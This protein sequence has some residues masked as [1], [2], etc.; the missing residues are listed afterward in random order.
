MSEQAKSMVHM[1]Y[2]AVAVCC[3][4]ASIFMAF[5]LLLW[6]CCNLDDFSRDTCSVTI[7]G[8]IKNEANFAIRLARNAR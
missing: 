4:I 1:F 3:G 5:T 7:S 6:V 8:T 2:S